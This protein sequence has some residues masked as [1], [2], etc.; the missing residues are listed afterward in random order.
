MQ[1]PPNLKL[2]KT[3]NSASAPLE[4]LFDRRQREFIAQLCRIFPIDKIKYRQETWKNYSN[5]I[6]SNFLF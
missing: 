6:G 5:L 1:K 2:P 3:V 4:R